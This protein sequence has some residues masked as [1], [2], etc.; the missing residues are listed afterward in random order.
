VLGFLG[1]RMTGFLV[2]ELAMAWLSKCAGEKNWDKMK[3]A[4]IR[5]SP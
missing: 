5:G 3:E 2:A 4:W 1:F